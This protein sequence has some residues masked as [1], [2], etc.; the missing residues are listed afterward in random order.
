MS[1]QELMPEPQSSKSSQKLYKAQSHGRQS[2]TETY[3]QPYS[4]PQQSKS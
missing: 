3:A 1:Q 4:K 2:S